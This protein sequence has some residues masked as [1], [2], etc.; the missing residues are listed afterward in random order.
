MEQFWD[1]TILELHDI[2]E[3][4]TR[5][6]KTEEKVKAG[7][8]FVLAN[9]ISSRIAY[10]F[11]NEKDRTEDMIL[12]PWEAYPELFS[13]E[14]EHITQQKDDK[15]ME[16]QRQRVIDWANHMNAMRHRKE[17]SE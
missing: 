6:T 15:E 7:H 8:I 5:M 1:S 12:Q 2:I 4:K 17:G 13:E 16:L 3:S 14:K 11:A 10:F 9:A